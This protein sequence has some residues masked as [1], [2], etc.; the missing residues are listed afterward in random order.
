M[1]CPTCKRT[2]ASADAEP[3]SST[4]PFCSQ[5]CRSADLGSWLNESFRIASDSD[6]EELDSRPAADDGARLSTN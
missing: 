4:L 2:I 1:T 3:R 6:D 5:R